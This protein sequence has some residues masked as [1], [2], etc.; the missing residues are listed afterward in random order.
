MMTKLVIAGEQRDASDGGTTEIRNP[1]TGELVDR[2]AAAT[3]EDVDRAIDAAETAFKKWSAV[4]PPQRAEVLYKAAHLL[5]ERERDLARLLTQEQGKPLRE[6][7]LEIRRFA[8]TLEHYAGLAK[9]IRGGYVPALDDRRY[10]M[11]M[12]KPIGVCGSIVPWNFPVSLLGNKI[13]PALVTGNTVVVKPAGT[14]PLTDIQAALTLH[15]AGLPPGVLNVVPGPARIVGE[16]LLRDP[17]VRKIGFTGATATGKHVME[18]AAQNVKRVTLELGGSDPMIVCD[19]ANIDEAV[20]AASVGRFFNCGQACLAIKRLYLF[21]RI[22]DQFVSK[23]LGK[24][25]K[26]RVGNGL[27]QG[28]IVGPLHTASQR[29]EIAQQVNDA[30]G[31]GARVLAG[32]K[33]PAGDAFS[34]GNFYLPTLLVDVNEDS[35]VLQEEVFG[36]VLPIVR[37]KD[38]DEAIAKANDSIYGLGSSIWTRDLDTATQAAERLEAGYTWIN[39]P[40]IIFDELPFGGVKQSGL[41]KEHG[42]EALD[43]YM[44]TKS[45]V[46]A[47]GERQLNRVQ[48]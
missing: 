25:E 45:V 23:L 35:R 6:A 2:V 27:D 40:Q 37:V 26:L 48:E 46:V 39:S 15:E 5:T 9:S 8:H 13:G 44:E 34:K 20:S 14:T 22:Y 28:V 30:I 47:R 10:G 43:Y 42:E 29:D 36:P 1:A 4:P 17:R 11:I 24:V 31:R 18:V 12:K 21:D 33:R 16:T 41:G 38:L 19:D 32:G 3:Q 7:V